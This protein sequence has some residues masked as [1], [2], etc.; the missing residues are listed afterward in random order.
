MENVVNYNRQ[1]ISV[2]VTFASC[3]CCIWKLLRNSHVYIIYT[4]ME[5]LG[6]VQCWYSG[7]GNDEPKP[8]SDKEKK[9]KMSPLSGSRP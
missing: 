6:K 3:F 1:I 8:I 7:L 9:A 5:I 4:L 2:D